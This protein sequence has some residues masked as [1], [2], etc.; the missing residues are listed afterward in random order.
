MLRAA[1]CVGVAGLGLALS[2]GR[3]TAVEPEVRTEDVERFYAVYDAAGGHPTA[4]QLESD[5]LGR[6]SQGLRDLARIRKITGARIAAAIE[7]NPALYVEARDCMAWFPR[8]RER[9]TLALAKLRELYPEAR[10]PPV[11]IAVGPGEPVGVGSPETGVQ[12]GLEALCATD[13]LNPDVEDRFVTVIAHEFVHV[14]Q[15]HELVD[16]RHPSVLEGSLIEGIAEFVGEMMAGEK[17][18][19]QIAART[20]GREREIEARFLADA[21]EADVSDWLF[22][23]TAEH[24]GDLGYWV[25]YRIAKSYYLRAQDR[26][27]ALREMIGMRDPKAFLQKSGWHPGVALPE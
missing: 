9:V 4:A 10:F 5:Y 24:P 22:N 25:G 3:T 23:S 7:A 26:R 13:W 11:T 16:K 8:V 15:A 18:Y 19:S 14:Q 2:A 17:V 1:V 6:G 12:I 20:A 21:D 27:A